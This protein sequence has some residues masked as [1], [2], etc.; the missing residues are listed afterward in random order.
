MLEALRVAYSSGS[1][2]YDLLEW[3]VC[4]V[5]EFLSKVEGP[6]PRCE[7]LSVLL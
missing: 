7:R 4:N 5:E 6:R 1:D 2:C 3:R